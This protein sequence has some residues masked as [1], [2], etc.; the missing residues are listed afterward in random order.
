MQRGQVVFRKLGR[1]CWDSRENFECEYCVSSNHTLSSFQNIEAITR[2]KVEV[3]N[4]LN[5]GHWLAA[6]QRV[7]KALKWGRG[8]SDV[9]I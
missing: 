8:G 5:L 3:V 9:Y 2:R 7:P 4:E 1:R 6:Y